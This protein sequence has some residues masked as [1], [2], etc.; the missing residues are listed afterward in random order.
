MTIVTLSEVGT[1][2]VRRKLGRKQLW[3]L[4]RREVREAF[5]RSS[6]KATLG[7]PDVEVDEG[8][9]GVELPNTQPSFF[10]LSIFDIIIIIIIMF[11][12]FG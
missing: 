12:S 4:P 8:I 2:T 3:K 7:G 6:G 5:W 11:W 9:R 1:V 10:L